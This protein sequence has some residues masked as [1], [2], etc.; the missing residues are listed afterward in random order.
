MDERGNQFCRKLEDKNKICKLYI[1][2]HQQRIM[3]PVKTNKPTLTTFVSYQSIKIIWWVTIKCPAISMA[4]NIDLSF[5]SQHILNWKVRTDS[6]R[7]MYKDMYTFKLPK[8][9][10]CNAI[11]VEIINISSWTYNIVFTNLFV[12]KVTMIFIYMRNS[13]CQN[14]LVLKTR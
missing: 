8:I 11:N 13:Q 5:V 14:L 3:K 1:I 4:I 9:Q 2:S 7:V 6:K 12:M 10:M